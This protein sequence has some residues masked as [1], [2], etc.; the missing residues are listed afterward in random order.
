MD[1]ALKMEKLPE[2]ACKLSVR[3][4][5]Q[6]TRLTQVHSFGMLPTEEEILDCLEDYGYG[7]EYG[8]ARLIWQNEK[9]QAV[10]SVSLSKPLIEEDGQSTVKVLV[11]GLLD[12]AAEQRRFLST[13]NETLQQRE[14]TLSVVLEKLMDSREEVMEERTQAL[15]LDLALQESEKESQFNYK[16]R[17][18]ETLTHLGE[19]FIQSKNQLTPDKVKSLMLQHPELIDA[20]VQDE[21]VVNLIGSRIMSSKL[22]GDN[23]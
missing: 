10:R 5:S 3:L 18:L 12:M 15:A 22:E 8:Y 7:T 21:E 14:N 6:R 1:L 23:A 2:T 13:L 4:G 9:G 16:E 17:A 11:D 20:L 19:T